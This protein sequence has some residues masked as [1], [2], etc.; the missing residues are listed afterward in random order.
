[1]TETVIAGNQAKK[2]LFGCNLYFQHTTIQSAYFLEHL[3]QFKPP[4]KKEIKDFFDCLVLKSVRFLGDAH[5]LEHVSPVHALLEESQFL[6]KSMTKI[7]KIMYDV[8]RYIL[9]RRD[10]SF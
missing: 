8:K 10:A 7:F 5:S 4:N 9:N 3:K 2:P 1:M 6:I